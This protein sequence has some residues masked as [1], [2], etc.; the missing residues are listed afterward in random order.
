[1]TIKTTGDLKAGLGDKS[2][3]V[4]EVELALQS[5]EI[6]L[7]VHSAKDLPSQLARGLTI[8]AVP[9]RAAAHDVC[10]GKVTAL[11]DLPAGARIGTSSLRRRSQ[12]LAMR[13][14]LE[15]EE[16]R[17]NVDT[18]LTKL[19]AGSYDAVVLAAAGLIRLDL[20]SRIGFAFNAELMVPAAGQ[21][22][23][24]IEARSSDG[25]AQKLAAVLTDPRAAA[26]LEAERTVVRALDATCHT[27]IGIHAHHVAD[28]LI[29]QAYLGLPDGSEWIRDSV[30]GSPA[31][32][33]ELGHGLT[34][35]LLSVGA[36]DLLFRAERAAL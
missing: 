15:I 21:G 10:V 14:D 1:M 30:E 18:R 7:A 24:V 35:R 31:T 19:A 3:F 16:L 17:G 8:A 29:V 4:N 26:E 9:R 34:E 5:N 13:P 22:A 27:P 25:A 33:S 28:R 36:K 6:D 12:L 2:R 32:P 23:L 11:G 20:E